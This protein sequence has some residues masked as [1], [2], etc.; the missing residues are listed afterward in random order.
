MSDFTVRTDM[1]G[2]PT[3]LAET[4]HK[5]PEYLRLRIRYVNMPDV[6]TEARR[7]WINQAITTYD[8]F[9]FNINAEIIMSSAHDGFDILLF[10]GND[11][12]RLGDFMKKHSTMM[13]NKGKICISTKCGPKRRAKL[14]MAGFD[15]VIDINR[16][17]QAEFI[18]RLYNIWRRYN[19]AES[20]R[21]AD[22]HFSHLINRISYG[23]KLT[24]KQKQVLITIIKSIN[25]TAT[26]TYLCS[27]ASSD[28]HPIS[29]GHLK[30]LIS[31]IRKLLKPGYKIVSDRNASYTLIMPSWENG[32]S[33]QPLKRDG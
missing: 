2:L 21:I 18:A 8:E 25:Y 1:I 17:H 3:E 24:P 16:M 23:D 14:L 29:H 13:A 9:D 32:Q 31:G 20:N 6:E 26:Y 33:M 5:S 28:I 27:A 15:D 7:E 4:F 22:H 19:S 10:G 11:P 30:V 12:R